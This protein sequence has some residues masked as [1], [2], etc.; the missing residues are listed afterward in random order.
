MGRRRPEGLSKNLAG[1]LL[2]SPAR[3]GRKGG[4]ATG[5]GYR[6]VLE[7]PVTEPNDSEF[8]QLNRIELAFNVMAY[9]QG[10]AVFA[11]GKANTLLVVN[12][13]ILATSASTSA[14]GSKLAIAALVAATVAIMLC[15]WVVYARHFAP[16]KRDKSRLI[17]WAHILQ[18]SDWSQYLRDFQEVTPDQLLTGFAHQIHDLAHVV[19]RKFFAYRLGQTATF[20]AAGLWI[21]SLASPLLSQLR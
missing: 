8:A 7:V 1:V 11:D 21:A 2:L 5:V 19:E 12:S 13:I 15:L 18:R 4:L 14:T 6:L 20:L 16:H 17:F 3:C 9:N 10:F